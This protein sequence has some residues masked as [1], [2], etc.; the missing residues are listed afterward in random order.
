MAQVK[1]LTEG[2]TL[3]LLFKFALPLLLGQIL[4]QMYSLID[5]AIVGRFLGIGSLAAVGASSSITFLIIGFCNGCGNGFCIPVA[6]QFGARN[7]RGLRR[8]VRNAIY[9]TAIISVAFALVT[10]LLCDD[11]LRWMGTPED[12]YREA[13]IYLLVTFIGI[14]CT[15]FYNFLGGVMRAL[16]DS[17]TPFRLLVLSTSMNVALDLLFI[18]VFGWGVAGAG[19]ATLLSQAVSAVLCYGI[20]MRKY[21]VLKSPAEDNQFRSKV[22]KDLLSIGVPMGLQFSITAIGSIMLQSSNNRL[23]TDCVAAFTTGMRIKMLFI[24]S[25]ESIGIAMATFAG[26]NIGAGKKERVLEG[27]KSSFLMV[28]VYCVFCF[29]VLNLFAAPVSSLFIEEGN[30]GIVSK[31]AQ[32]LRTNVWFYPFLGSL[33]IFRYSIQ[34]MGYTKF[35]MWSGV[36]EMV[37]R[38]LISLLLVPVA[39]YTGVCFGD[40]IAWVAANLFLVPAFIYVYRKGIKLQNI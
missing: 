36:M 20:M 7:Y 4:Q 1:E 14:P 35:A 11:I 28:A 16:G 23:G 29:V 39:G 22:M 24:C 37:A 9:L 10:S 34:G 2:R 3:P 33:C 18:V 15:F 8:Y 30:P 32:F 25:F 21:D 19:I 40:A 26:Q 38:T 31:A 27:I 6:Q 17:R 5:A 13:W 12:I